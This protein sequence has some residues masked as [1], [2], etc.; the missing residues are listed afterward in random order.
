[1][2]LR[3]RDAQ[4]VGSREKGTAD[5]KRN[6]C[7]NIFSNPLVAS[8]LGTGVASYGLVTGRVTGLRSRPEVNGSDGTVEG[9]TPLHGR[10][11][12]KVRRQEVA[13]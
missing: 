4:D 11:H 5:V 13:K 3:S 7:S 9:I 1:M 8:L 12:V 2:A 6:L 10:V